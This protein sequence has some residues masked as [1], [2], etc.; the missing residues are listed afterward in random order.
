MVC[1]F[2]LT[3]IPVFKTIPL[4]A[5]RNHGSSN[6]SAVNPAVNSAVNP[7][8]N[9]AIDPVA[10]QTSAVQ[11]SDIAPPPPGYGELYGNQ[12][13]QPIQ[14]SPSVGQAW[15][16]PPTTEQSGQTALGLT[17]QNQP[18]VTSYATPGG[19]TYDPY[20]TTGGYPTRHQPKC[21]IQ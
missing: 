17:G 18:G 16:N 8:I 7:T 2:F 11:N 13:E 1:A 5:R 19:V 14:M 9:P 12:P 3:F 6:V 20:I 4:C 21:V 15:H 10:N